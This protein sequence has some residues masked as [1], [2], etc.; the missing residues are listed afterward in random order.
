VRIRRSTTGNAS[1]GIVNAWDDHGRLFQ[2]AVAGP[3]ALGDDGAFH[4]PLVQAGQL[5]VL[6][7]SASGG[8][9][10]EQ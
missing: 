1:V 2:D 3:V 7:L 4:V 9:L 8:L 10:R 6:V 5:R